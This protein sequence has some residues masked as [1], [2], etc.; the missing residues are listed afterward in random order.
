MRKGL[1]AIL[2]Q[3]QGELP[4]MMDARDEGF[5]GAGWVKCAFCL[6]RGRMGAQ[7]INHADNCIGEA[8]K[9]ELPFI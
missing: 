1:K 7:L 8:L 3:L 4:S 6:R 2:K 5:I 9:R